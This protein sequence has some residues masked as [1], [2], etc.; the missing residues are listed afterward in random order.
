MGLARLIELPSIQGKERKSIEQRSIS[1]YAD[2]VI[3][4]KNILIV[5]LMEGLRAAWT[6]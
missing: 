1:S 5:L 4:L 2:Y 6:Y 3:S